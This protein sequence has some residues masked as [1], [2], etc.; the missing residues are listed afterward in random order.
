MKKCIFCE[1][2][3]TK[4]ENT[5]IE[6]TKNFYVI[7]ALGAIVEG[8][9]IIISKSHYLTMVS[10]P[11]DLRSEYED[12]LA[13]YRGIFKDIYGDYPMIFEHGTNNTNAKKA[14]SVEHA[15]VHIVN[16]RFKDELAIINS[17]NFN[18]NLAERT[19]CNYIKYI[20]NEGISY[21]T[22]NFEGI[23]QQMR[24]LIA[25][26]LNISDKYNWKTEPFYD[27]IKK[28]I[29]KLKQRSGE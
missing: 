9:V 4:I 19:D 18:K 29:E 3:Q 25:K 26:D 15:H 5:I 13:R 22:Y 21:I 10:L 11:S 27:N 28:T 23:S 20:N 16:H 12:I 17:L 8:Y 6:E 14:N 1:L 7:P 2:D 24:I